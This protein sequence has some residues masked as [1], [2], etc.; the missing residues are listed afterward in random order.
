MDRF[1]HDTKWHGYLFKDYCISYLLT[2]WNNLLPIR[3][4][5]V[6]S[7]VST[8]KDSTERATSQT[9]SGAGQVAVVCLLLLQT[10]SKPKFEPFSLGTTPA[11]TDNVK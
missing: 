1:Q 3:N 6:D 7:Q 4:P 11:P 8:I 5:V 9:W 2:N 10:C